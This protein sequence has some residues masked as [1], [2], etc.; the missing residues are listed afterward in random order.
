MPKRSFELGCWGN[1]VEEKK[2]LKLEA[3]FLLNFWD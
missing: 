3:V 2:E 1:L